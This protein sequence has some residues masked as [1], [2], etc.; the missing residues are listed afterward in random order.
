MSMK[1]TVILIL[2]CVCFALNA[3]AQQG[4]GRLSLGVGALYKNGMDV[5]LAYE[6]E[7][8]II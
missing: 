4:S 6:P 7:F 3:S 1:K 5:T 8:W 2:A